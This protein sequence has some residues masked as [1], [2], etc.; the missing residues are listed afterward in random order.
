MVR[1]SLEMLLLA[2]TLASTLLSSLLTA[3]ILT[4]SHRRTLGRLRSQLPP[5]Q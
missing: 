1:R 5:V 2:L 4:V 3:L